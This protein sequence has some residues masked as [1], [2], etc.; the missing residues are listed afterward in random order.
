MSV[1]S[2]LGLYVALEIYRHMKLSHLQ[3]YWYRG[4]NETLLRCHSALN[5]AAQTYLEFQTPRTEN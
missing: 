1:F 2:A 4:K 3:N 5:I